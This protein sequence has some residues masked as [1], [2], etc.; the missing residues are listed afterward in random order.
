MDKLDLK[1]SKLILEG[2]SAD[3]EDW[4]KRIE[5]RV[6]VLKKDRDQRRSIYKLRTDFYKGDQSAYTTIIGLVAKQ[7]KGHANAVINY[8]GKSAVKIGYSLAN[9][10]PKLDVPPRKI[11][12]QWKESE[13]ARAQGVEDFEDEVYKRNRFWKGSYRRAC[14]NQVVNAD[15][16]LK[17]YPLNVGTKEEP[18]WEI[19]IVNYEK[20]ENIMIG[21][22]GDDPTQFDYVIAEDLR[23][24]QSIFDEFGIKVPENRSETKK[25][26][27]GN[28]SGSSSHSGNNQWGTYGL[29]GIS[30]SLPSGDT[31]VPSSRVLEYDDENVYA[32]KIAG[33]LVQLVFKDGKTAPKLKYW[34]LIH[35]IP[36]LGSPW[37]IS[38]IDYLID[39][40]TELNESSN[41]QRDYIRVGANQK[42]VAYNMD[43]FD[44]ESIKPGSGGVIFVSSP[45]G[46]AKFEPL[47][48]NVNTFPID[49]FVNRQQTFMY[50]LGL[51]KVSYGSVGGDS[52]RSKAIDYQTMVDLVVFKRDA[53]ELALDELNEKI[54]ILGDFY[55]PDINIF[56]D[57]STEQFIIRHTE[58]D[59]NDILPITQG[60]KVVS[61]V[62]KVGMGLPFK[63][64]FKE[65]G[66]RDVDSLLDE[67]RKEAKDD[68][69]MIFRSKMWQ[70]SKGIVDAQKESMEEMGAVA[71]PQSNQPG[72]VLSESQNQGREV[73]LPVSQRGGTTAYSSPAGQLEKGKQ[74]LAARGG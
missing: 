13:S 74:N 19:K 9:N 18:I 16:A 29:Q 67:M 58:F 68:D 35:N 62:N 7:K 73:S 59:W 57:P 33:E 66:Y 61:I 25:D 27:S 37:S 53:W 38:D 28:Q 2:T 17:I 5:D 49:T 72:P 55:F 30:A 56:K 42:Y 65:M 10:P 63:E 70:L 69:L 34:I 24:N 47:T 20:M 22:R 54:Q 39:P 1:E 44:P 36:N 43:E 45:D 32:L 23:S 14:F 11:A 52:G 12:E 6:S 48:T 50:D 8:A 4:G 15:A 46:S 64:A 3:Q 71:P 26:G 51:P 21:W 31:N 41:E 60:D 40:Q